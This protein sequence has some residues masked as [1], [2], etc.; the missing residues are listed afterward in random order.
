MNFT[1]RELIPQFSSFKEC[2]VYLMK[3]YMKLGQKYIDMWTTPK[4]MKTFEKAFTHESYDD[5]KYEKD[6]INS[7]DNN[8][9]FFELVGDSCLNKNILYYLA[10]RF[11]QFQNAEGVKFITKMKLHAVS[12]AN[13][14]VIAES[15]GIYP[16]IRASKSYLETQK[17]KL[18][19][20]CFEAFIG[21]FEL[22]VNET[23]DQLGCA[24]VYP[25]VK[26]IFDKLSIPTTLKGLSDSISQLK[27][28]IDDK[29]IGKVR[30]EDIQ[31]PIGGE[32]DEKYKHQVNVMIKFN[33]S[34][35]EV[36]YGTGIA[37]KVVEAKKIG[38]TQ[39]LIRLR[40][41]GKIN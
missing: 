10:Q 21:A 23:Y 30:Y 13:Y 7:K 4:N 26:T 14:H 41:E 35:N 6:K 34:S 18:L 39:A 36:N 20:D 3:N 5:D 25:L 29:K 1:K 28:A 16:W 32:S 17:Y 9:E 2:I 19:E 22:M 15:L 12:K 33:G 8:Y 11:P 24:L 38:A 31:I 37:F 27:E 40:Q